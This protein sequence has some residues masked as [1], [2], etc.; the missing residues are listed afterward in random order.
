MRV[1]RDAGKD[2]NAGVKRY[3]RRLSLGMMNGFASFR[4]LAGGLLGFDAGAAGR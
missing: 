4:L 3:R 1:R 2:E